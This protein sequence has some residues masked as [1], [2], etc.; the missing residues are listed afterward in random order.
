MPEAFAANVRVH[1]KFFRRNRLILAVA[2][3]FAVYLGFSLVIAGLWDTSGNRFSTLSELA[4]MLDDL[5]RFLTPVL[6]LILVF[7]HLRQKTLKVV[8]TKPCPPEAWLASGLGVAA[9]ISVAAHALV[10][11][12]TVVL[13]L[14]WKIPYQWGFLYTG[15]DS[16]VSSVVSLFYLALL[17]MLFHPVLALVLVSIFNES[18]LYSLGYALDVAVRAHPKNVLYAAL[19]KLVAGVFYVIPMLHPFQAE[20]PG[21]ASSLR[22][23][24]VDWLWLL[25]R[26][27]YALL[28]AACLFTLTA[29]ALRRK[30]LA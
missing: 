11:V 25:A 14:A 19:D 23:T 24:G 17:T 16:A 21:V 5:T 4:E 18:S 20:T 22:T 15:L 13:S 2:V 3:V 1:L 30:S 10:V 27:G 9:A 6:G 28:A 7:T 12:L 26:G 29:I 8:V